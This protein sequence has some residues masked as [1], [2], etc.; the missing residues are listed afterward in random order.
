MEF[1]VDFDQTAVDLWYEMA[2]N[3]HQNPR[4]FLQ[5]LFP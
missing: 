5:G 1:G 3:F 4:H 2:W